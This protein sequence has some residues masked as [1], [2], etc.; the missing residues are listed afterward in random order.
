MSSKTFT[1]VVLF[2]LTCGFIFIL[3]A[4]PAKIYVKPVSHHDLETGIVDTSKY[5][6][7]S[8]GLKMV[9]VGE[10]VYLE[11]MSDS[12]VTSYAWTANFP[13]NSTSTLDNTN[14][15]ITTFRPDT[16][17][18]FEVQ[19]TINGVYDTTVTVN[20][21]T[22]SGGV[23][24]VD[25][26]LVDPSNGPGA[27][28]LSFCHGSKVEE[29]AGVGHSTRFKD[30]IDGDP[31]YYA[32]YCI[33]CHTLGYNTELEADNG[34]FDDVALS[35][36]WTFPSPVATGE[37]DSLGLNYPE[38]AALASIQCENCHGPAG[39][40]MVS[41][42][43]VS[44]DAGMCARC[45]DEP[46]RHY[47]NEQWKHSPHSFDVYEAAHGAGARGADES[48]AP[49]HSG[50]GFI[51]ANDDDYAEGDL[52]NSAGPGNISCATCH[53]PHGAELRTTADVMLGDST[54]VTSGGN[55]KLCMN[56]HKSRRDAEEYA[57]EYHDHFGPHSSPQTD[58]LVGANAVSFGWT[59]PS[60]EAHLTAAGACVS[61][62]MA[63][64]PGAGEDPETPEGDQYGRDKIGDHTFHMHW[65]GDGVNGPIDNVE[66][67][68][69]CHGPKNSFTDFMADAD[70]DS[71]G[72]VETVQEETQGMMDKIAVLLPPIGEL[73]VDVDTNYTQLQFQ[74]AYNLFFVEDDGSMG[75]H[76]FKFVRNLLKVTYDTLSGGTVGL[77]DEADNFTLAKGYV[78]EQNYPNPFNPTTTI[79]FKL[80]KREKVRLVIYDVLGK[81]IRTLVSSPMT[82]G[83]H[84][85]EWDGK[86]QLGQTVSTGVYIYR[87]E[88]ESVTLT[89]KMLLVK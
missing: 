69:N 22:Y 56:C 9:G 48:C 67:C 3:T 19:L 23:G 53:E 47:R 89:K 18:A 81:S 14:E 21:A 17:G 16:V 36:G 88:G 35:M 59:L 62:H 41:R 28:G 87:L 78:L 82:A 58:M 43:D 71:D 12:V 83:S 72:N 65:E 85:M 20:S 55:G 38:L 7:V 30:G 46:W 42:P 63:P 27:C 54:F 50:A 26:L 74:S 15:R 25:S 13:A 11:G 34:G 24:N 2:L 73:D 68:G 40:H 57:V 1:M 45:H 32:G 44:V 60:G 51:E 77:F 75:M 31:P 79:N 29:W 66:S 49:C 5:H 61:C 64:T 76:N 52:Y 70:Y 6:S 10:L 84:S 39:N 33:E 37:W 80:P 86:D 8:A 4:Q